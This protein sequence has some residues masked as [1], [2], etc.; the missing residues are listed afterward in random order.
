MAAATGRR[1]PV[2]LDGVELVMEVED[3]FDIAIP[4]D[5][6]SRILRVGDL[7]ECVSKKCLRSPRDRCASA[8]TFYL[9]RS[10]LV[11]LVNVPRYDVRPAAALAALVPVDRRRRVWQ[12]FAKV[13]LALPNLQRPK[14]LVVLLWL[15]VLVMTVAATV[16]GGFS[17]GVKNAL[18]FPIFFGALAA[19]LA[20]RLSAPWAICIPATCAKVGDAVLS[21]IRAPSAQ[22]SRGEISYKVRV[23]VAE[24]LGLPFDSVTEDKHLVDDFHIGG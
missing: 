14:R 11:D 3:E 7:V 16:F 22:L 18:L 10:A 2:G 4:D 23:I 1:D 6:A 19:Y 17:L 5:E 13:G 20:C 24:Q 15:L 8:H 21:A 9:L 12:E